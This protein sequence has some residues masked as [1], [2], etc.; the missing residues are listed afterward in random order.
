MNPDSRVHFVLENPLRFIK[1][2]ITGFRANQ[3]LL[4][5]GAVA[6][7]TLLSIVPI[8]ILILVLFSQL[9][10]PK[11]LIDTLHEYLSLLTPG[12]ADALIGQ[13]SLFVENWKVV[14]VFGFLMLLFFSS[15]AFTALENAMSVIFFHRVA[16]ERRHFLIS[17]IIPYIYILILGVGLLIVSVVSSGLHSFE[18]KSVTF[19]GE[20]L[21]LTAVETV[22]LY[23]FGVL[24]EILLLTSLYL[25]MPVGKLQLRHALLGG[26]TATVL[27]EIT[28]HILVWYYSTI[29]LVNVVYGVFAATIVVLI[30]LEAASLILLLGAQVIAEYER[31]GIRQSG[32]HG[33]QTS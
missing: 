12:Q 1:R 24:G 7:Y 21:S 14:G 20:H 22:L 30:S 26:V 31:L 6:Y 8:M 25:V 11:V 33:L 3:G 29:S 27:W 2:V 32:D 23:L 9:Y 15:F 16:I 10:N 5:S 18:S 13:I 4:L 19:M 17:A 28:R